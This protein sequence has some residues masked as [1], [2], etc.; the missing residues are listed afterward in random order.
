[1]VG[2][3]GATHWPTLLFAAGA[4]G[5]IVGMKRIVPKLPGVLFAVLLT[6]LIS[7]LI[8]FEK[9]AEVPLT[10]IQA[11]SEVETIQAYAVAGKRINDLTRQIS[12]IKREI[13]ELE[14]QGGLD[15]ITRAAD[16]GSAIRPLEHERS[17]LKAQNNRRQIELH[18]LR[19]EGA[20]TANGLVFYPYG[21]V[22]D[23]IEGDGR[24]WRFT[25]VDGD[26]ITLS[27]GGVVVGAIPTGLPSFAV[28]ELN[29]TVMIG[30][31]PAAI[32]MALI[33]FITFVATL[34]MAPAIANGILLGMGLTLVVY[35]IKSMKPR[36]EIVTRKPDGS[37]GGIKANGLAPI[38]QTVVPVRFDGLLNFSSVAFFENAVLDV[39]ADFPQCKAILIIGS[40]IN[41]IDASGEEKIRELG[42]QLRA[43]GVGLHFSGRKHQVRS[44]LERTG[45]VDEC[46]R[47]H[48]FPNKQQALQKLLAYYDK[49]PA[50][51]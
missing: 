15:S 35:L 42:K 20:E 4:Y 34:M 1:V 48:F 32:V 36:A 17:T 30:L 5:L 39:I 10:Q 46:G 3:I 7:A 12:D 16:V 18:R 13:A 25:G 26:G 9:K 21:Q 6:T 37:L 33:G 49:Q 41:E 47:D 11:P 38:S 23:S 22:P 51:A 43:A 44:T 19:L 14:R 40:S 27:S 28:P 2:Q 31:L 24:A 29:W 8:G 45:L 50:H